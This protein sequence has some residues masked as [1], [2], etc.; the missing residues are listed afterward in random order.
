MAIRRATIDVF[1]SQTVKTAAAGVLRVVVTVGS[2]IA[3]CFGIATPFLADSSWWLSPT[4]I[5]GAVTFFTTFFAFSA[6]YVT[7][8]GIRLPTYAR[9]S[10]EHLKRFAANVPPN[11]PIVLKYLGFYPTVQTRHVQFRDLRRII[12]ANQFVNLEHVPRTTVN[13]LQDGGIKAWAAR[14]YWG[15]FL[16]DISGDRSRVPGIIEAIWPQIPALGSNGSLKAPPVKPER[17]SAAMTN[18]I[19]ST[20][21]QRFV[22]L[23]PRFKEKKK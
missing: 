22:P 5:I 19:P 14:R 21:T 16:V 4:L 17:G 18:R 8:I 1:L 23:P 7:G 11:T 3:V 12:P 20:D 10:K 15:R 13:Q 6:P 9:A 2:G